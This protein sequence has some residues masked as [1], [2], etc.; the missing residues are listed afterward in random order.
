[1]HLPPQGAHAVLPLAFAP[2][3][4]YARRE[5]VAPKFMGPLLRNRAA[6]GPFLV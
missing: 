3:Y 5:I 2:Q 4:G 6:A 1:M